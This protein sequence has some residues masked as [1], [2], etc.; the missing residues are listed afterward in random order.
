MGAASDLARKRWA[1]TTKE[2]RRAATAKATAA[3]KAALD[4]ERIADPAA[5][6]EKMREMARKRHESKAVDIS[7]HEN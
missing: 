7:S 2:Q 3:R 6:V 1:K 5:F 4:L